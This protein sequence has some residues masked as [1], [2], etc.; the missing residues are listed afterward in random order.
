MDQNNN[1][2][3][4]SELSLRCLLRALLREIWT[5]AAC[6]AIFAMA[7]S[8]YISWF[9]QPLY[10]ASMTY[11]VTTREGSVATSDNISAS[12]EVTA[13]MTELLKE[14]VIT[15]RLAAANPALEDFQGT[16]EATQVGETNLISVTAKADGPEQAFLALDTL[17]EIFPELSD[18]LSANSVAQVIR[19]PTVSAAP[20][21]AVNV[22]SL[23]VKCGL[24]GAVAMAAL[25][26]FISISMETVQ[27]K[28]GARRLLDAP[29]VATVGHER[30]NRTLRAALKNAT[31]GLQ[32]FAPTTSAAYT[33]QINSICTRLE[34]EQASRGL[35]T[36]LITGVGENEGKSTIAANVAAMLAM[37]GKKVALLDCDLRKP[38]MK[39][40]FD[41]AYQSDFGVELLL[42][43]PYSRENFNRCML[44]H[45]RL[46]LYMFFAGG[47][48][49]KSLK[50]LTGENMRRC[51]QD[52]EIFDYV[53]I[54]TP[55]MGFF[56]DAEAMAELV[57]A[58]LL[59]VR[60]DYTPACDINDA[61]DALRKT[62]ARFLGCVL[63]D[64]DSGPL[65]SYSYGYGYGYGYGDKSGRKKN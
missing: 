27:T 33:E 50:L 3:R 63:N 43:V 4:L 12:K 29:I 42:N 10:Q 35:R 36:F 64:M 23:M 61:A 22:R 21:N 39:K 1:T 17:V 59:V 7:A 14:D 56:P 20:I 18:Y 2:L 53:I 44:R 15:E 32:V 26:L 52:M 38:A 34:Q 19:R 25:V 6:A 57:D 54:D 31:K 62:H 41:E 47:P 49:Q 5:I 8:L 37:K 30:K 11:A 40:F 51:L 55:P 9:H 46:G 60:Q 58:A 16:I 45:K 24:L 48:D 65:T 28:D 13:V